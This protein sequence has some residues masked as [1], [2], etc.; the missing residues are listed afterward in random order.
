MESV[1]YERHSSNS[2]ERERSSC[3]GK[4]NVPNM[5]FE[6][7]DGG[8]RSEN[9]TPI[10]SNVLKKLKNSSVTPGNLSNKR[11]NS[12]NLIAIKTQSSTDHFTSME[13]LA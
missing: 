10:R 1:S 5:G 12:N 2:I 3:F 11:S 13:K 9:V 4:F 6:M 7:V 8:G